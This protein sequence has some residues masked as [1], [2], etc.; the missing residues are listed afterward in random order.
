MDVTSVHNRQLFIQ[1]RREFR[2]LCCWEE[3]CVAA[4]QLAARGR[5]Q[6]HARAAGRRVPMEVKDGA[7]NLLGTVQFRN[8]CFRCTC[9]EVATVRDAEGKELYRFSANR[10][11]CAVCCKGC[12]CEP[13]KEAV[14]PVTD[15]S[16]SEVAQLKRVF[17]GCAKESFTDADNFE[18]CMPVDMPVQHKALLLG[19]IILLDFMLFEQQKNN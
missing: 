15:M 4:A 1:L 14:F 6:S 12:P 17:S 3:L 11:D 19:G 5:R 9:T 13:C 7:G 16:G 10:C 8:N 18:I 2:C